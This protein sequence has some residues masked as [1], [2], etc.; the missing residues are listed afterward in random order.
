VI[1]FAGQDPLMRADICAWLGRR[2]L[3]P[4]LDAGVPLDLA[5][6]CRSTGSDGAGENGAV[7][8]SWAAWADL[9][10][11]CGHA[12]VPG[13]QHWDPGRADYKAIAL[14][15]RPP[16]P[17]PTPPEDDMPFFHRVYNLDGGT[18]LASNTGFC[19][20][21]LSTAMI[22]DFEERFKA[23]GYEQ[24]T[25]LRLEPDEFARFFGLT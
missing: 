21:P 22:D 24:T 10:G 7:R 6:W 3:G 1:G 11:Q 12:N 5:Q 13:N 8:I 19:Q 16:Q 4:V 2:V 17:T 9:N 20:G 23:A 25:S 14:A 15:A 18:G